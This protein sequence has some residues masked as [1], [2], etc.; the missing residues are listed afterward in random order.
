MKK[1]NTPFKQMENIEY[2][3]K[4]C[5]RMGIPSINLFTTN[6]LFNDKEKK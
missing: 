6:D 5:Q 2:Y 1:A 3:L 4:A